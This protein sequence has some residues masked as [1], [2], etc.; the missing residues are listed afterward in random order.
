MAGS[1]VKLKVQLEEHPEVDV[2]EYKNEYGRRALFV[3]APED[4]QHVL[5]CSL[6]TKQMCTP[7]AIEGGLQYT[8]Q[9][10]WN[11]WVASSCWCRMGLM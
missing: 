11:P 10:R 6:I 5:D 9:H 2:D 7:G 1:S 4:T 3:G 8:L